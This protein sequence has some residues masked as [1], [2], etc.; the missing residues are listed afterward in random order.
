VEEAAMAE[1]SG[2]TGGGCWLFFAAIAAAMSWFT[3]H[4]IGWAVVAAFFGP[5]YIV[6]YLIRY[7][8]DVFSKLF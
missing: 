4:K 8:F 6:Y 1:R 5:L 2:G 3:F 7:G